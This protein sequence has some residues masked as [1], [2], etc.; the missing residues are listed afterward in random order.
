MRA[1]NSWWTLARVARRG[2]SGDLVAVL[3]G[4]QSVPA[5]A[6]SPTI[7]ISPIRSRSGPS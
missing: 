4:A 6:Q 7:S 2:L 3:V 1:M 5:L